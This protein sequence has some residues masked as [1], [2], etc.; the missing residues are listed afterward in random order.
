MRL[1]TCG[2]ATLLIR[3]GKSLLVRCII[4]ALC[5]L[6]A[7]PTLALELD[8]SSVQPSRLAR[9]QYKSA[10]QNQSDILLVRKGPS[11]GT[12]AI[13]SSRLS[14]AVCLRRAVRRLGGREQFS[15]YRFD[16]TVTTA[17]LRSLKDELSRL[18][19][20]NCDR[21]LSN[22]G[23][24]NENASQANPFVFIPKGFEEAFSRAQAGDGQKT[25]PSTPEPVNTRAAAS[26]PIL[27]PQALPVP[28]DSAPSHQTSIGTSMIVFP[29]GRPTPSQTG[30][31]KVTVTGVQGVVTSSSNQTCSAGNTCVFTAKIGTTITFTAYG[32]GFRRWYST[33]SG[34]WNSNRSLSVPVNSSVRQI[35]AQFVGNPNPTATPTFGPRT[36]TPRPTPTASPVTPTNTP[37]P[38]TPT[39]TVSPTRTPSVPPPPL[40]NIVFTASAGS[41]LVKTPISRNHQFQQGPLSLRIAPGVATVVQ[42][43]PFDEYG[44]SFSSI[45][46]R[47][48]SNLQ[49]H[50]T[51]NPLITLFAPTQYDDRWL[52][53]VS[54]GTEDGNR[55]TIVGGAFYGNPVRSSDG[56]LSC[57]GTSDF[58]CQARFPRE[59]VTIEW[60]RFINTPGSDQW[61]TFCNYRCVSEDGLRDWIGPKGQ[62]VQKL[63]P[64]TH[65]RCTAYYYEYSC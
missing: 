51:R 58:L 16:A 23:N 12:Q 9:S 42:I 24:E 25:E 33:T 28:A 18:Y 2:S 10:Q 41:A 57:N 13:C 8:E 32:F 59:A 30:S 11:C 3:S 19:S 62:F 44:R 17:R 4:G 26:N 48:Q 1:F 47:L 39:A 55:I 27:A 45:F 29:T 63:I 46:C 35:F 64:E 5:I 50:F 49:T 65:W 34:V 31:I 53:Q 37:G 54:Y 20:A 7:G 40:G 21:S 56:R 38:V 22:T 36:P 52:C 6:N 43:A 61:L 14:K 60:P 15:L